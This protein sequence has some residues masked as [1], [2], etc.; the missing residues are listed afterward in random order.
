MAP[1]GPWGDFFV[2]ADPVKGRG[3]WH[4]PGD[5]RHRHPTGAGFAALVAW[6]ERVVTGG[7]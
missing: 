3:K 5:E 7:V 1:D 6:L 2:I 4:L